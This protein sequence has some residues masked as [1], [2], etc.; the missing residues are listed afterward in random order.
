MADLK[1][2]EEQFQMARKEFLDMYKNEGTLEMSES[3]EFK[4]AAQ[5]F[6]EAANYILLMKQMEEK[7]LAEANEKFGRMLAKLAEHTKAVQELTIKCNKDNQ[8]I[9]LE[10]HNEIEEEHS[11]NVMFMQ[12]KE[13]EIKDAEKNAEKHAQ[14]L[15]KNAD[16]LEDVSKGLKE[17]AEKSSE[18]KG[19]FTKIVEKAAKFF[20]EKGNEAFAKSHVLLGAADKVISAAFKAAETASRVAEQS[21][22]A[23]RQVR[24]Y[25]REVSKLNR[26][27]WFACV[28]D[29]FIRDV[30]KNGDSPVSVFNNM[31]NIGKQKL[32][33]EEIKE[34]SDELKESLEVQRRDLKKLL[35]KAESLDA[36]KEEINEAAKGNKTLFQKIFHKETEV[37]EV[38][39]INKEDILERINSI[40]GDL[41][42]LP[43]V[44]EKQIASAK[45]LTE[46]REDI[47]AIKNEL[48]KE[49]ESRFDAYFKEASENS[50]K[51]LFNVL[52]VPK[53]ISAGIEAFN[54]IS[55]ENRE[56][57]KE[58]TLDYVDLKREMGE[59]LTL[60]ETYI[61]LKDHFDHELKEAFNK[62][63]TVD[64]EYMGK[65]EEEHTKE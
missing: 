30:N 41:K 49:N 56:K 38:D 64:R 10:S 23:A 48:A 9:P 13:G 12:T 44:T 47:K 36:Q 43:G 28:K 3:T 40:D 39:Q 35:D 26:A 17:N 55:S 58:S 32:T 51:K 34:M 25:G 52:P 37:K 7:D 4:E 46:A 54:R 14:K 15:D 16:A 61:W 24:E 18:A 57:I 2:F 1:N 45:E 31:N 63:D 60:G 8:T 6:V 21:R 22:E 27:M 65:E 5:A 53:I 19:L 62:A 50:Q 29:D 59:E 11:S 33:P 20:D 42:M